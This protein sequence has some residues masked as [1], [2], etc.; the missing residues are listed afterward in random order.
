LF[1]IKLDSIA[2]KMQMQSQLAM[3]KQLIPF[4]FLPISLLLISCNGPQNPLTGNNSS[5][6]SPSLNPGHLIYTLSDQSLSAFHSITGTIVWQTNSSTPYQEALATKDAVYAVSDKLYAFDAA[7]GQSTWNQPLT[8]NSTAFNT[9]N[10][11]VDNQGVYIVSDDIAFA[12]NTKNGSILWRTELQPPSSSK[13]AIPNGGLGTPS[14]VIIV[15]N[16]IL[17]T[18][19]FDGNA[20]D[21]SFVAALQTSHG[22]QL[23]STTVPDD[24]ETD[25][26]VLYFQPVDTIL[27]HN[28]VLYGITDTDIAAFNIQNG[29]ILWQTITGGVASMA[30]TDNAIYISATQNVVGSPQ[31]GSYQLLLANGKLSTLNLPAGSANFEKGYIN[32]MVYMTGG[33]TGGDILAFQLPSGTTK[34]HVEGTGQIDFLEVLGGNVYTARNDGRISLFNGNNG[35]TIWSRTVPKGQGKDILTDGNEIYMSGDGLVV[36]IEIHTGNTLWSAQTDGNRSV[37]TSD[38]FPLVFMSNN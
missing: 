1:G 23:W 20:S 8:S 38:G 31:N 36:A 37:L 4:L 14:P 10:I 15:Q 28:N 27:L 17:Y 32:N 26:L 19:A 11:A 13:G 16:G 29:Q 12:F 33:P 21:G 25:N 35:K 24:T 18:N 22:N 7:S 9:S 6:A 2:R 30:L 34:W 3:R 5:P